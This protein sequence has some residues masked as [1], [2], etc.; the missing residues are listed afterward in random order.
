MGKSAAV[1]S[2]C[3]SDELLVASILRPLATL[4]DDVPGRVTTIAVPSIGRPVVARAD[5]G[6]TIHLLCDSPGGPRYARSTD[7]GATFSAAIPVVTGDVRPSG[8][9]YSAWDM[10]VGKGGRAHVAMATNAWKLKLPQEEW[11]FFY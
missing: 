6:G 5:T 9:E 2:K 7:G 11:G 10:A 4:A 3:Y 1:L 8:L